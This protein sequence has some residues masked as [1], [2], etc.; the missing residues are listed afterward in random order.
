MR[1]TVLTLYTLYVPIDVHIC[2]ASVIKLRSRNFV[3]VVLVEQL[4]SCK[5]RNISSGVCMLVSARV[6]Q[7]GVSTC[8]IAHSFAHH[9][10]EKA[11]SSCRIQRKAVMVP[12]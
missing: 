8:T 5:T 4:A 1:L 9:S 10:M 11:C 12:K 2:P 7:A 6:E 3:L